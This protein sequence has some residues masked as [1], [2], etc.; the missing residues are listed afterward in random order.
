VRRATR[1][2]VIAVLM[3]YASVAVAQRAESATAA[4]VPRRAQRGLEQQLG[5]AAPNDRQALR[6]Q[7]R[8]AFAGVVRKQLNLNASQMQTLQQ[9]DRKYEQQRGAVLR[10]ER[11]A[12]MSLK[13][14]MEDSTGHPDQDKIAQY[15]D[16]LVR[17]QRQRAELLE[18]EQKE[19]STFLSPLQRAQYFSLKERLARKLLELQ[20]DSTGGPGRRGL[21]PPIP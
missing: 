2:I 18:A 20:A 17:G 15:L 5:R 7:V 21:A 3:S 11:E 13:A 19:L 1:P 10:Q 9:T 4:R 12:R 16:Q 8:Q 6:V 14:T